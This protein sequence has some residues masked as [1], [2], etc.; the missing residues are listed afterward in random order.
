FALII[1]ERP[2]EIGVLADGFHFLFAEGLGILLALPRL[3]LPTALAI[4][5][6]DAGHAEHRE[7]LSHHVGALIFVDDHGL[8][9]A[10]SGQF[11]GPANRLDLLHFFAATNR[12]NVLRVD[13][14]GG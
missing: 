12:L 13:L 2:V 9:S 5:G 11:A 4:V 14:I 7:L 8:K 6:S 3:D 10:A 1:D